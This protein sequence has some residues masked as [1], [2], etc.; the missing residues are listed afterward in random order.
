MSENREA[1]DNRSQSSRWF[2]IGS[3]LANDAI[4]RTTD[5]RIR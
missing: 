5:C 1:F 4:A 2:D 3:F